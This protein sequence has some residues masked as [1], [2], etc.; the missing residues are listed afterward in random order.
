MLEPLWERREKHRGRRATSGTSRLRCPQRSLESGFAGAGRAVPGQL[1]PDELVG[2]RG[3]SACQIAGITYRQLDYWAA[4][5]WWSCPS[6]VPPVRAVSGCTRS[7]HPGP[8]DREATPGHRHFPAQHPRGGRSPAP[9]WVQDLA[10]ITLFS[11]GTT[12]YECTSAEEVVDLLQGGQG[13]FGIAVNGA[14]RELT[15]AIAE[16]PESAPTAGSYRRT[17]RRTGLPAARAATARSAEP[18]RDQSRD[19]PKPRRV[20]GFESVR[21]SVLGT[22]RIKCASTAC[23]RDSRQPVADAGRATPLRQPLRHPNRTGPRCL[24]KAAAGLAARPWGKA[25]RPLNLSGTDDRGRGRPTTRPARVR[26]PRVRF[27]RSHVCRPPHRPRRSSARAHARS[28]RRRF[29]DELAAKALPTGI[30]DPLKSGIAPGLD[31]PEP[32]RPNIRP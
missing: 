6:G 11:D 23:G 18:Y 13:V 30:L 10:N 20:R 32:R 25:V 24:W 15:G 2:Y 9:A 7:G 5:R 31:V 26:V 8:Q 27:V 17:G 12:V 14:M 28:H 4:P 1:R 3:P 16:F 22:A 29:P 21:R 19:L